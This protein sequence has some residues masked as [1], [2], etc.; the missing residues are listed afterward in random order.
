MLTNEKKGEILIC[1]VLFHLT[2]EKTTK[3]NMKWQTL[4]KIFFQI[5]LGSR[6]ELCM[7]ALINR[8]KNKS[9]IRHTQL[10]T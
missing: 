5:N 10:K 2:S 7:K 3:T 8:K 9:G 4:A 1:F 6:K